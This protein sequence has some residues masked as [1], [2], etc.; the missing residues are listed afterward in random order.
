[1]IYG[2]N[3]V[4]ATAVI[5][6]YNEDIGILF[7]SF[8]SFIVQKGEH[9]ENKGREPSSYL[10]YIIQNYD[11]LDGVYLFTQANPNDT[12]DIFEHTYTNDFYWFKGRNTTYKCNLNGH[13]QDNVDI[14]G[15]LGSIDLDYKLDYIIFNGCCTFSIHSNDIKK[16]TKE[17]YQRIY[18]VLMNTDKRYEY[19][20][21][22]LV[23]H[24]FY[25]DQ[26][27]L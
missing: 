26:D 15:F 20:F 4:K 27:S 22:R 24:I 12:P 23:R 10:W 19:A 14:K 18:N 11:T 9:L 25:K 1:M 8:N 3:S 7:N 17:Y 16:N 21:E 6:R 13:P 2:V 5:A